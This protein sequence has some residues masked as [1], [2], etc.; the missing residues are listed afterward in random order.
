MKIETTIPKM[1]YFKELLPGDVFMY[2]ELYLMKIQP[3]N[4]DNAIE[5]EYGETTIIHN[6]ERVMP[7][8]ASLVV[9]G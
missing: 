8:K 1:K 5:F 6:D 3:V 7:V 2:E 4:E 9:K